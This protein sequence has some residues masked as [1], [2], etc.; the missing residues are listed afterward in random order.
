MIKP[1]LPTLRAFALGLL[2]VVTL[3]ATADARADD[4]LEQARLKAAFVLNFMKFTAW[5]E[6]R[7]ADAGVNA[8][9]W[10]IRNRI[11]TFCAFGSGGT[12]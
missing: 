4:W 8:M 3:G 6:P 7:T 2:A 5:P 9:T 12:G 1:P 10:E 11:G